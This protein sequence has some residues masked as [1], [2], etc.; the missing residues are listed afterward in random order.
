M[1]LSGGASGVVTQA[2]SRRMREVVATKDVLLLRKE[3]EAPSSR[4]IL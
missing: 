4:S 3:S 2:G 1:D